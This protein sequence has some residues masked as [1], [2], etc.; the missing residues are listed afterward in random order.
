MIKANVQQIRSRLPEHVKLQA[1]AKTRSSGEI[2]AV[3]RAGVGIIGMN[4]AQEGL[5]RYQEVKTPCSW[6]FIGHLQKNKVRDIVR[7]FDMIETVDS[8]KL[9]E[10]INRRAAAFKKKM[11]V[12]VEVNSGREASKSG[13]L[14]EDTPAFVES[15]R[16]YHNL[17]V[18]GLMTMG[19]FSSDP[20]ASRECFR[21]TADLFKEIKKSIAADSDW[22]TL[23]MGMSASYETAVAE[24][25]TMV[26]IG[27]A[28]FG[29]R[30]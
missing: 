5:A 4:Y 3:V 7:C 28:L 15:I 22:D 25:A 9:A 29:P 16:Q 17:S 26:R 2:E 30:F 27:T 24:G 19:Y 1:A 12:L 8:L 13:I 6:H 11:S 23:S 20:E 21:V 14:P 18:R 10:V